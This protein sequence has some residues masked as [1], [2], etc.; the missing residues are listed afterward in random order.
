[1]THEGPDPEHDYGAPPSRRTEAPPAGG[2]I[3]A[4]FGEEVGEDLRALTVDP[5]VETSVP[6]PYRR[7]RDV[8]RERRDIIAVI[9]LGGALGSL[10]RW[11]VGQALPHATTGF[12]WS[13]FLDNVPGA[14][15]LGILMAFMLDL[16]ATT[17]LVRPFLGVGVLGGYTTFSTWMLD[18]H[19]IVAGGDYVVAMAYVLSTLV[20]G[21]LAVWLGAVTG[22]A[23]IIIGTRRVA[24]RHAH[25]VDQD[26]VVDSDADS[27]V[28]ATP[29]RSH[30]NRRSD[31]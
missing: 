13:T 25:Q 14:F 24:R 23:V 19:G 4:G 6:S 10:A 30:A 28:A 12:A 29:G 8:L 16:W 15:L 11:G 17:R 3:D 26:P 9:A 1:M 31:Q 20:V 2:G 27:G 22:R 21:L 7:A 18:T 5:D